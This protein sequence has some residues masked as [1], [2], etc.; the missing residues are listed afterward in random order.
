ML[1]PFFELSSVALSYGANSLNNPAGLA[2]GSGE[3][4]AFYSGGAYGLNLAF[5]GFGFGYVRDSGGQYLSLASAFKGGPLSLG[6]DYDPLNNRWRAGL[7]LRPTSFL[8]VGAVVEGKEGVGLG[9]GLR[10]FK[11]ILTLYAGSYYTKLDLTDGTD[12]R[13]LAGASPS[14]GLFLQPLPYIGLRLEARS[15]DLK[16]Y[17]L[18]AGLEVAFGKLRLGGVASSVSKAFGL[19]LSESYFTPSLKKGRYEVRVKSY[20]EDGRQGLL[21]KGKRFYD[22]IKEV[23]EAVES[24]NVKVIALDMRNFGLSIAQ[25]EELRNL[26]K[27]AKAKGKEVLSFSDGYSTASYYVASVGKVYLAPAG[28]MAF[29]GLSAEL[30]FFKRTFDSLGIKVQLF[31]VGKYKSALEPFVRDTMSEE[32]REQYRRMLEVVWGIWL[33]DVA[34]GRGLDPDSLNSLIEGHLG[35][36]LPKEA[37]KLGL[38]DSII[39]EDQWRKLLKEKGRKVKV[40]EVNRRSWKEDRPK[41]A[42]VVAEGGIVSG[43]SSYNPIPLFGGKTIGDRTLV[44]I[45]NKLRKDKSVK[46]VV[47]RVNSPGGSALA[48]DNIAR[49]VSLLSKEKPVIVSMGSVAASGG[50][51]ISA[52]AD[53]ILADRTTLTGSIGV[54]GAKFVLRDFYRNKLHLN[55]DVVKTYP[56]SDAWSLWREMDSTEVRKVRRVIEAVYGDFVSVVS[57]GRGLSPD[58]VK[59]IGGGRVW[60]GYDARNVGLV[61]AY[62]GIL[63]AVALAAEKA[64]VK[65]YDVV[66]YPKPKGTMDKVKDLMGKKSL[67][68][69]TPPEGLQILYRMEYDVRLK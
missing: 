63:D 53:T 4:M 43:E 60:T 59:A 25:A 30:T 2:Y 16:T 66:V 9:I 27:E 8:S 3:F 11:D 48:S 65:E 17:T 19:I 50:Y 39:Y 55:R 49:A 26:L 64:K 10:P 36:F 28:E 47:L 46:A 1:Y 52:L 15:P 14:F 62:G 61:D 12:V 41:I 68:K 42:V 34:E 23:K 69:I 58:S 35:V 20:T 29:P 6:G 57:K 32:N 31:R 56:F 5:K 24:P 54:I 22:F 21:S 44:K 13:E 33:K 18:G 38:I 40:V 51:Y 67:L 45:L 37:K 7:L